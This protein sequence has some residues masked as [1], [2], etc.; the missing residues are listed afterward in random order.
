M[1]RTVR[2]P[3][4]AVRRRHGNLRLRPPLTAM[5]EG[6]GVYGPPRVLQSV[7]PQRAAPGWEVG[8]CV[9]R[10]HSHAMATM[11]PCTS[12]AADGRRTPRA[13]G[14][15]ATY[16]TTRAS[17]ARCMLSC[18]PAP[19]PPPAL[20]AHRPSPPTTALSPRRRSVPATT[21]PP[22]P[23][24]DP[25]R[26]P[27]MPPPRLHARQHSL[28]YS[29]S[30]PPAASTH[31]RRTTPLR[32]PPSPS[33]PQCRSTHPTAHLPPIQYHTLGGLS[34]KHGKSVNIIMRKPAWL[35]FLIHPRNTFWWWAH[36]GNAIYALG[37]SPSTVPCRPDSG[38]RP[39]RPF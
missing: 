5:G 25:P 12:A 32:P 8:T 29:F 19:L 30:L 24:A 21:H 15:R 28:Q 31:T 3:P 13:R 14:T 7:H 1:H 9:A 18:G 38:V 2:S 37:P 39:F 10:T 35:L 36:G 20:A 16:T 23:P 33:P 17:S 4:G 6:R 34:D 26:R 27:H 11:T 22:S